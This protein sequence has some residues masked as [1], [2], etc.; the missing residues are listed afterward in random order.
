MPKEPTWVT[1]AKPMDDIDV[2]SNEAYVHVERMS[3]THIWMVISSEQGDLNLNFY[4]DAPIRVYPQ[5]C[6]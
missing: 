2:A 1:P 3:D 4:S 5:L 6:K